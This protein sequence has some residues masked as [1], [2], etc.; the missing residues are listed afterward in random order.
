[1]PFFL[2]RRLLCFSLILVAWM[3]GCYREM[4]EH[5]WNVTGTVSTVSGEPVPQIRICA[6]QGNFGVCT[7]S[8]NDGSFYLILPPEIRH[9]AYEIC[10][11]DLDGPERGG[12]YE[13]QCRTVEPYTPEPQLDFYLEG[14]GS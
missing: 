4:E 10:A 12:P 5:E 6:I 8:A 14:A 1:M 2:F 13:V 11:Y 9:E 3:S 7:T